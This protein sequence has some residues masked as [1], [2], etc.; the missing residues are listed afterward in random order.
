MIQFDGV[1]AMTNSF[2]MCDADDFADLAWRT[3]RGLE[4][5]FACKIA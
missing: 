5:P 2:C 4:L 3:V 1:P